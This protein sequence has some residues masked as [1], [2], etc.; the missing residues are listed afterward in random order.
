MVVVGHF[1]FVTEE[2]DVGAVLSICVD[3]FFYAIN[4]VDVAVE[5]DF[6]M[7]V[8]KSSMLVSGFL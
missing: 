1:L 6:S 2:V 7:L 8:V 4:N 3:I 5:F